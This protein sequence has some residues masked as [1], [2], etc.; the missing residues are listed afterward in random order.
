MAPTVVFEQGGRPLLAIG[1]PGGSRIICYVSKALVG[2]LDWELDLNDAISFPNLCNRNGVTELEVGDLA[3]D[4][5]AELVE[6]GHK[7]LLREMTSGLHAIMVAGDD[8]VGA[9]DPRREGVVR[10]H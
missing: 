7:V 1:S 8:L 2:V 6:R 5:E 3:G 10:G 4:L 9:A